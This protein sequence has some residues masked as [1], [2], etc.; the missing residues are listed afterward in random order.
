M[1]VMGA[2]GAEHLVAP[3]KACGATDF[4]AVLVKANEQSSL[5]Q[6]L[7]SDTARA[8]IGISPGHGLA[9]LDESPGRWRLHRVPSKSAD[10]LPLTVVLRI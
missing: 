7:Q 2:S 8:L 10:A 4:S 6:E 9:S 3:S 5:S 1:A